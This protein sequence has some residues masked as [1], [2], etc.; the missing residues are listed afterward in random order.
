MLTL[1]IWSDVVCPWCWIAKKRLEL[2]LAELKLDAEWR[3]HAFELGPRQQARQPIVDHLAQKYRVSAEEARAM[4]GRV[5]GLGAELGIEISPE[6]QQTTGTF[7]AHRL[8]QAAQKAGLGAAMMERLH[9]AHF[10]EGLWVADKAVLAGLAQEAGLPR[11]EAERVL[12][13]DAYAMEVEEDL[14]R[15]AAY[16]IR[17]VP[18]TVINLRYAVNGAQAVEA[19]KSV[20]QQALA[21]R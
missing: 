7:D 14:Q 9:K 4:V 3:F 10:S 2:A 6:K 1:D 20:L 8:V 18:F 13:T 12:G 16:E 11:A 19:F 15:A 17:G 5:Q 21:G